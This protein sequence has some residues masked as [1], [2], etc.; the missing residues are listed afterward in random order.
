MAKQRYTLDTRVLTAFFFAAMP[1]VAFGSF[2]V[3]NQAK[4]QLRESV[5]VSLEQRAV[6]TKLALEQYVGEHVVQ[7]R[8]LALDPDV[9]QA[10]AAPARPVPEADARQLEQAWASGKDAKLNA[11]LLESPLAARLKPLGLVRP[12]IKQVQIVDTNGRVLAT[13]S[14]GGR[15]FYAESE[16][17]KDLSAPG[18]RARGAPGPALP[19]RGLDRESPRDRLPRPEP[20]G[21][22]ARG[23]PG[24]RRR[25]R[26]LHGAR[27]RAH[28]PHGPRLPHPL[29]RR[30]GPRLGRERAHPEGAVPGLR[31]AAQRRG[32]LP[33]GRVRASRS[34]AG[35][36][37][38]GATGRS[39]T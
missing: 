2:I 23:R 31:L 28:R 15:L 19:R 9:Q 5:G 16:W 38:A 8:V 3:V 17:F 13:S 30:H 25:Q 21:R 6:Q 18:G 7:L 26:S 10:L 12:S 4:N 33:P 22:L 11:S 20:G 32:G 14:R 34:S 27:P 29:D 39:P 35:R 24:P 1:F 36:D 37:R